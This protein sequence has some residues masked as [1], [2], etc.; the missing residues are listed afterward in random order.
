MRRC[1]CPR[2]EPM[3]G[4]ADSILYRHGARCRQR[5]YE[6]KVKTEAEAA[7]LTVA[8]TLK[9]VRASTPT[10]GHQADAQKAKAAPRKRRAELRLSYRRALEALA[11]ELT[12]KPPEG[13]A[14]PQRYIEAA[15]RRALSPTQLEALRERETA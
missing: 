1:A 10:T 6:A 4:M 3:T 13:L 2:K 12:P 11:E 7:G 15:L 14:V 8:P 9:A 5:A